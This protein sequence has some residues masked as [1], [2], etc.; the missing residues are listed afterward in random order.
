M[1]CHRRPRTP[2]SG[3]CQSRRIRSASTRPDS[4]ESRAAVPLRANHRG[5]RVREAG[6]Q[7]LSEGKAPGLRPR[8]RLALRA[9]WCR[10]RSRCE[11]TRGALVCQGSRLSRDWARVGPGRAAP[12][13]AR[14]P[15]GAGSEGPATSTPAPEHRTAPHRPRP[16]LALAHPAD[17]RGNLSVPQYCQQ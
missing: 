14:W 6:G 4:R 8:R 7:G 15:T 17:P 1:T 9:W 5:S 13:L 2:R 3:L 10:L 12:P 16:H 11:R